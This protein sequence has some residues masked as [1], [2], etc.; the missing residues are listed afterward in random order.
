MEH[1]T[2]FWSQKRYFSTLRGL[3]CPQRPALA[4]TGVR[5][6]SVETNSGAVLPADRTRQSFT[7]KSWFQVRVSQLREHGYYRF[8]Y[9]TEALHQ[10]GA[11]A[12]RGTD[13]G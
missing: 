6:K 2:H 12:G 8:E 7:L 13:P 3:P 5:G 4:V 9:D 11:E 1:H 10:L